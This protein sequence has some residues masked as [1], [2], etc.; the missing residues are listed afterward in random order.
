MYLHKKHNLINVIRWS[1]LTMIFFLVFVAFS[2][3]AFG[4]LGGIFG[5]SFQLFGVL[6]A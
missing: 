2:S 1:N 3:I 6:L 4:F 5:V